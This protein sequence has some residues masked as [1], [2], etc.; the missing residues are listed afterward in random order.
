MSSN[1]NTTK[2]EWPGLTVDVKHILSQLPVGVCIM[3]S[4][5]RV[6]WANPGFY[7]QLG[8]VQQETQNIA[9]GDLPIKTTEELGQGI[10]QP[11]HDA[12]KRLRVSTAACGNDHKVVLFTDVSDLVSEIG[13]YADL[14]LEV[15]RM[16]THTGLLTPA[17]MYRELFEQVSRSRRYGNA[18][19]IV[20]IDIAGLRR[21]DIDRP[22]REQILRDLGLKLA[23]NVRNID[24]AGRLSDYEFLVV[25]PET[26]TEGVKILI[27]KLEPILGT[28]RIT[29]QNGQSVDLGIKIGLAQWSTT[30]DASTLLEK[31]RPDATA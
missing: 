18:L 16:D 31:A 23:D 1:D 21:N 14:L 15:A 6:Q 25:L 13:G 27:D 24:F 30:D 26:N 29:A 9:F 22:D 28:T 11:I 4:D 2:K 8:I 3:G 7:A 12:D 19:A 5:E 17:S 10:Y 20:R